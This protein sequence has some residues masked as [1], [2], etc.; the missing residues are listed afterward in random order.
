MFKKINELNHVQE[1]TLFYFIKLL[2]D[3][4]CDGTNHFFAIFV[5][6]NGAFI[7]FPGKWSLFSFRRLQ[8]GHGCNLSKKIICVLS[9]TL[10]IGNIPVILLPTNIACHSDSAS[11]IEIF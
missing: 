8:F 9:I 2:I 10:P 5:V 7:F 11:A 6:G 4:K 1:Y 3:T